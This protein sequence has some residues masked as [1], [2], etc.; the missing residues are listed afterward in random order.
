MTSKTEVAGIYREQ[1]GMYLVR[2]TKKDKWSGRIVE[3]R[4]R[5]ESF[6]IQDAISV[7]IEL[8]RELKEELEDGKNNFRDLS[9]ASYAAY[10]EWYLDYQVSNGVVRPN[11]AKTDCHVFENFILPHIGQVKLV[12]I[13][14]RG[15]FHFIELLKKMTDKDGIPYSAATYKRAWRLFRASIRFAVK[16][17]YL[18]DDPTHLVSPRFLV[19]KPEKEKFALTREQTAKL[20]DRAEEYDTKFYFICLIALTQG[21]R[22]C[23]ITALTFGDLDFTSNCI[24]V[25]KSQH[26]G[27]LNS[28]VKNGKSH[29]SPMVPVLRNVALKFCETYGRNKKEKDFLFNTR[30]GKFLSSSGFNKK[31]KEFCLELGIPVVSAHQLRATCNTLYLSSGVSQMI[32]GRILNHSSPQM[33]YH[34]ARVQTEQKAE[35]MNSVWEEIK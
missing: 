11:V 10:V 22:W 12:Q 4:K 16:L 28:S 3:R 19:V 8:V 5:V 26:K 13:T 1:S 32:V 29:S 35:I 21:L 14:K 20:L 34:Y 31:L 23:E 6:S 27:F 30:S 15:V 2:I 7:K 18:K 25:S 17:N 9:Q 24:H 33:S